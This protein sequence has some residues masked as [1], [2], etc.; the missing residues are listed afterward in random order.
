MLNA[1]P[2]L[3]QRQSCTD[4]VPLLTLLTSG[5]GYL[6]IVSMIS[7]RS[8]TLRA[9]NPNAPSSKQA[10]SWMQ[11]NPRNENRNRRHRRL[12][13]NQHFHYRARLV[14]EPRKI[15]RLTRG[16][17]L[18]GVI[19][20]CYPPP[21]CFGRRLVVLRMVMN[22]LNAKVSIFKRVVIQSIF[23]RFEHTGYFQ[24]SPLLVTP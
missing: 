5:A 11:S 9:G 13:Q 14:V 3:F 19:T 15:F 2:V 22:E 21:P 18:C 17:E 10:R 16:E 1:F 20:C 7:P 24:S 23:D 4:I 6:L 8:Q 12:A